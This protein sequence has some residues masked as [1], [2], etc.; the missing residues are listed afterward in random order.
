MAFS[1]D[2]TILA[3]GAGLV[4]GFG[5]PDRTV[6]LW[7]VETGAHKQTLIGHTRSVSSVAFSPDG[8]TLASASTDGT[9]LLWDLMLS[10]LEP[11][12]PRKIA[13]DVNSDG[14]VDLQDLVIVNARL[15]Q[16]GQNTADVNG[17]GVVDIVDLALVADA[18]ADG[19]AAPSLHPQM[20]E[21]FTAADVKQWLSE[22]QH[23]DLTD[24]RFQRGILF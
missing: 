23:L 5:D 11:E 2:G 13:E 3:S 9:V 6:R 7:D 21:L 8:T 12:E 24:P 17:D 22:A 4:H 10:P 20:L 1:P 14:S 18:I 16:K 19:A 15:G